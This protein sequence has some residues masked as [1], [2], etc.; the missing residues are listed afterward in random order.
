MDKKFLFGLLTATLLIG[1]ASLYESHELRKEMES[2]RGAQAAAP[3]PKT[4]QA[5]QIAHTV[6]QEPPGTFSPGGDGSLCV[7][8]AKVWKPRA[9]DW[10]YFAD[11]P[12]LHFVPIASGALAIAAGNYS[13]YTFTVPPGARAVTVTGRFTATGGSGNDIM[14][15]VLDQDSFTNFQNRHPVGTLY[16]SGKITT[17]QIL[18]GPLGAGVYYL[19]FDNRYSAM[20]PKAVQVAAQL[21][22]SQP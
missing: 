15:Y 6:I 3:A 9:D 13:W 14:A 18:A 4:V 11:E 8:G 16:N 22:Y 19:V 12:Q 21:N 1:P 2:I 10:C 20:T 7:K 5:A 17:G